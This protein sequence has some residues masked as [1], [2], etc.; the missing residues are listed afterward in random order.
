MS[1]SIRHVFQ[2]Q[3]TQSWKASLFIAWLAMLFTFICFGAVFPFLPLLIQEIGT[4][5]YK[6]ASLWAGII[7]GSTSTCMVFTA[8]IWG[9]LS[10]LYGRKLPVIIGTFGFGLL[11]LLVGFITDLKLLW[12]TWA[13][14]GIFPGPAMVTL[15]LVSDL[16]PKKH[17]TYGIG[18]FTSSNFIG[19]AIGPIL[20]GY[21][22]DNFGF[23]PGF[24]I[25]FSCLIIAGTLILFLIPNIRLQQSSEYSINPL[26][27]YPESLKFIRKNNLKPVY[28]LIV[29]VMATGCLTMPVLPLFFKSLIGSS[30]A[31]LVTGICFAISG[32]VGGIA[33]FLVTYVRKY[34]PPMNLIT[35]AFL[36]SGILHGTFVSIDS[37]YSIYFVLGIVSIFHGASVTLAT[38]ML[39]ENS[40][41]RKGTSFGIAHSISSIAWG[42]APFIG[43]NAAKLMGL[44]SPFL[45]NAFLCILAAIYSMH[46]S[47]LSSLNEMTDSNKT[48]SDEVNLYHPNQPIR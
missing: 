21:V 37:V 19:F 47:K 25:G 45:V 38:S 5:D 16:L 35:C 26:K 1:Y 10:D 3:P 48:P 9:R 15:A 2:F 36:L 33:S 22:I 31:G 40:G 42:G 32:I 11:M 6:T 20:G 28:F 24:V 8:P 29:L 18:I 41:N 43:G 44:R 12:L 7:S 46:I 17:L 39:A 4:Y 13:G 27:I 34:V 23:R 30:D 14:F